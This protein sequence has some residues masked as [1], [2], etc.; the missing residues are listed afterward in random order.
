VA[1]FLWI[2]FV[3]SMTLFVSE[4]FSFFNLP[5]ISKNAS[6][7]YLIIAVFIIIAYLVK[8]IIIKLFG[9]IF[10]TNKEASA[11][12]LMVYL[13]GNTLGLAILPL[14]ISI[15]FIK[16]VSP[17]FFIYTGIFI[18]IAFIIARIIRGLVIGYNSTRF[19]LFYLF[20][21]LCA[22]EILPFVVLV[23]LFLIRMN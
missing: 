5:A 3:L 14:V 11:Y 6:I 20:L 8:V 19:S 4:M 7:S 10:E 1:I 16:Q 2:L 23:K 17:S 18:I 9:Y 15:A 12:I 21:Y 13:F 22:L